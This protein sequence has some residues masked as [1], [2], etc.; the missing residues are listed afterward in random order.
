MKAA[1]RA[2]VRR[3]HSR[4]RDIKVVWTLADE[5]L[6]SRGLSTNRR[7]TCGSGANTRNALC[8]RCGILCFAGMSNM[9]EPRGEPEGTILHLTEETAREEHAPIDLSHRAQGRVLAC[10]GPG[11]KGERL[12]QLGRRAVSVDVLHDLPMLHVDG[13]LFEKVFMES[14]GRRIWT[15]SRPE[16]G[17]AFL[18]RLPITRAPQEHAEGR[19]A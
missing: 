9:I 16:V 3:A 11:P 15:E 19:V 4:G 10:I 5:R 17:A 18:I 8:K 7:Y 6:L 14:H 12:I 2:P 1:P 13:V